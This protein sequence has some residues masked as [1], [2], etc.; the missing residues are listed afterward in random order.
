MR[1]LYR[2]YLDERLAMFDAIP[3]MEAVHRHLDRSTDLQKQLWTFAL[4]SSREPG[5]HPN[6][7]LGV[8]YPVNSLIEVANKRTW[9]ALT[10]PPVIIYG[11]L[12][13]VA[14]ICSF[15]AGNSLAV[16][17]SR[18]WSHVLGFALLTCISVYVILEIEFP[19][20]GLFGIQKYDQ[21]LIDVRESMN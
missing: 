10:H 9:G 14:L 7:G 4:A 13:A 19:R 17:N 11:L 20:V 12:F 21:A 6:A 16:P 2:T 3:D 8:T 5:G 18:P 15:I 1:E